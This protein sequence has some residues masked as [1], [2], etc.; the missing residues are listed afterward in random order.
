MTFPARLDLGLFRGVSLKKVI[1]LLLVAP[2]A[3]K[4]IELDVAG[5][6]LAYNRIPPARKLD[7]QAS[8]LAAEK[9]GCPCDRPTQA[10]TLA[11][12]L[13]GPRVFD[14]SLNLNNM[15]H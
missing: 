14:L 2:V 9:P 12:S 10:E 13:N 3:S 6:W 7:S 8:S 15:R 5:F 1:Q 4:I 11:G